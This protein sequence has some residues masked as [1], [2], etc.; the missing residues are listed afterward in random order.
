VVRLRALAG[1]DWAVWRE[2]RLAALADA[3]HAFKCRLADWQHAD[4]EQCRTRLVLPGAYHVVGLLAGRPV[5]MAS[6]M[7]RRDG[8]SEL[9][10][11]C[12]SPQAGAERR[13]PA[14]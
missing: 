13:V 3:P 9:R 14:R 10:S 12:V 5:D 8:G 11:V 4:R 6:G 7:P 1:D 2:V